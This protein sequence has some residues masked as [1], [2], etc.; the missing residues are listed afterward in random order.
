MFWSVFHVLKIS[1]SLHQKQQLI[2]NQLD[3]IRNDVDTHD[4]HQDWITSALA[5]ITAEESNEIAEDLCTADAL[6]KKHLV[7][8][9]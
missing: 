7:R 5:R 8:F 4:R 2:N 1:K 3:E 6:L 9:R